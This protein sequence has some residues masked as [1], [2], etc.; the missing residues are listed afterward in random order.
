MDLDKCSGCKACVVACHTLNGLDDDESW[1]RV[2]AITIGEEAPQVRHVTTACHHCDEPACLSGCPVKAYEKDPITGIVRHLDDQCIGCKYCTMMCPYE[3]PQYSER[4]GIVRKCDMC[5]QRMSVGEAPACVQACPNEAIRIRV[6]D[7][8]SRVLEQDERLVPGAPYSKLTSPS[9]SYVGVSP[10]LLK[11]AIPHD[12]HIDRPAEAHWPL[13]VMLV[14]TQASVGLLAAERGL[15]LLSQFAPIE[16]VQDLFRLTA[17]AT[18]WACGLALIGLGV[19][20]LH[21]GQPLRAWRIFLGLRTSWLS[22]EAVVLGKYVG[23]LALATGLVWLPYVDSYLPSVELGP[24]VGFLPQ[25]AGTLLVVAA[26]V[27]GIAGLFCSGMIYVATRR[28]LWSGVRTLTL[29]F[30]SAGVSGGAWCTFV[31]AATG[32][33]ATRAL[34]MG[35]G[36]ATVLVM[37]AK[38][39]WEWKHLTGPALPLDSE[40]QRRSRTLISQ[41]LGG[42]RQFRMT[43]ALGGIALLLHAIAASSVLPTTVVAGVAF[44]AALALMLGEYCERII[45]FSSVVYDRMPGTMR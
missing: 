18:V 35:V 8:K 3:V 19:A 1:R 33:N 13:A 15:W 9:T 14:G 34:M 7:M 5:T 12:W 29:F 31:L 43:M 41:S 27:L 4:L 30:A 26:L 40:L 21:L 10:D 36:L 22:R 6:V 2:G 38:L 45:Y 11:A 32:S 37:V 39:V 25:S 44:A 16:V 20:P 28:E 23:L 42:L 24:W 17:W